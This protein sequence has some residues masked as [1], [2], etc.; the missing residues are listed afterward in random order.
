MQNLGRYARRSCSPSSDFP[1]ISEVEV[2][3]RPGEFYPRDLGRPISHAA[4]DA[5][6]NV[7]Y[8]SDF[9]RKEI[10]IELKRDR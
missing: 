2:V 1:F 5:S 9:R 3:R 8:V 7:I 4:P 10:Q 6:K